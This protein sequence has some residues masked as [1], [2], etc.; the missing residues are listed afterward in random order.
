M[1]DIN[2]FLLTQKQIIELEYYKLKS[3]NTN[4][5][6]LDLN[7]VMDYYNDI[8]NKINEYKQ[9]NLFLSKADIDK[10]LEEYDDGTY[11]I[12]NYFD[13]SKNI[14][15][16]IKENNYTYHNKQN[17]VDKLILDI[18]TGY[19]FLYKKEEDNIIDLNKVY[20]LKNGEI[21]Y[22]NQQEDEELI[23]TKIYEFG[24]K[25]ILKDIVY[26]FNSDNLTTLEENKKQIDNLYKLLKKY[27]KYIEENIKQ[28][29]IKQMY[30]NFSFVNSLLKKISDPT[31][32]QLNIKDILKFDYSNLLDKIKISNRLEQN[33]YDTI[34]ER[35][36]DDTLDT[37]INNVLELYNINN[38]FRAYMNILFEI[39]LRM[40]I[41]NYLGYK[42][43]CLSKSLLE[44]LK[45][46]NLLSD[47]ET[48]T[49]TLKRRHWN[50]LLE[51][52]DNKKIISSIL[53]L[54]KTKTHTLDETFKYFEL[55]FKEIKI[56]Y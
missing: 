47:P 10:L 52:K 31:K 9:N 11:G 37:L 25:I 19:L 50:Q 18:T 26:E 7:N 5:E 33:D 14:V 13:L 56:K 55:I 21:K 1:E 32:K 38:N 20:L 4:M 49:I 2:L 6:K 42:S 3:Q 53:Y 41:D 54:I 17:I 30:N 35:Y 48:N 46:S 44:Y 51:T 45:F 29:D 27:N 40:Y 8:N 16:Y 39:L 24:N 12:L 34:I 23:T 43:Y 36:Y 28:D 22:L 15:D